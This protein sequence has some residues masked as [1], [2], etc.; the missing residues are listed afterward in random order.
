MLTV[1]WLVFLLPFVLCDEATVVLPGGTIQGVILPNSREFL[2]VPYADPPIGNNRWYTPQPKKSWSPA[3]LNVQ[4]W[5][6]GCPQ[7]CDTPPHTCP[8]T[9]NEDCLYLNIYT[10]RSSAITEKLPV[11]VFFHG[12]NFQV[13]AGGVP[14]YNATYMTETWNVIEVTV[15]YRLGALGFLASQTL[16]GNYGFQDQ[17]M[18]LEWIQ[19]NIGLFGGDPN[20]VTISGQSA[21]GT[22][23]AA[24]LTNAESDPLFKQ[25]ILESNP[26]SLFLKTVSQA[27]IMQQ[28]FAYYLNCT[29]SDMV[30]QRGAS[31]EDVLEAQDYAGL[32]LRN[33]SNVL[34]LFMP[35]TPVLDGVHWGQQLVTLFHEGKYQQNKPILLGTVLEEGWL[36]INEAWPTNLSNVDY[37]LAVYNVFGNNSP[38]VLALYPPDTSSPTDEVDDRP[39][40]SNL[41]TDFVFYCS[42]RY[43]SRAISGLN[44]APLFV[45]RFDQV[46]SFDAWSPANPYCVGHVCHGSELGYLFHS[47][48]YDNSGF[49][50]TPEEQVLADTITLYWANFVKTGNP[51]LPVPSKPPKDFINWPLYNASTDLILVMNA[52]FSV[53]QNYQGFK[54]NTFDSFGPE[55]YVDVTGD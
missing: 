39:V 24:H 34:D 38:Q 53:A 45:Y 36:F 15:N 40:C 21:G 2:G 46:M 25:A 51:N 18:A 52:T 12:G 14:I 10:P 6:A 48:T 19:T 13:G 47:W 11:L 33:V 28:R 43:V 20:R 31:V 8:T 22:S 1:L 3:V 23:V 4:N 16:P 17:V 26:A 35:W 27:T 50:V 5:P 49:E 7:R 41:A 55:P 44:K 32:A 42:N 54:C 9:T 37:T 29:P 30:C